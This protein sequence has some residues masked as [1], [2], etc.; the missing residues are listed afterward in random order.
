MTR[1]KEQNDNVLNR[2]WET[3][4]LTKVEAES[5]VVEVD[6]IR[7]ATIERN[8]LKKDIDALGPINQNAVADYEALMARLNHMEEQREDIESAAEKL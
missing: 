1:L 2:L 6:S 5:H 3:H 7:Q 4:G 8:A